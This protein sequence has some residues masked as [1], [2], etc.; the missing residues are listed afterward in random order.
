MG[1]GYRQDSPVIKAT[2]L[3]TG[4]CGDRLCILASAWL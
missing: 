2:S 3:V 1:G 4:G